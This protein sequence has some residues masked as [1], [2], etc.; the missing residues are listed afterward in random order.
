MGIPSER[1]GEWVS[2]WVSKWRLMFHF[3]SQ[4]RGD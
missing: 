3:Y 4:A 2:E 1:V